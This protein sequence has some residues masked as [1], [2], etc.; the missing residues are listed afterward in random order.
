M[1]LSAMAAGWWLLASCGLLVATGRDLAGQRPLIHEWSALIE[2]D[3]ASPFEVRDSLI[4]AED[5][6]EI[7]GLSYRSPRGGRVTAMLVRPSTPGRHPALLFG[8]WG[9]GNRTEFLAEAK[10]LARLGAVALL[11]DYPWVRPAEWRREEGP[12]DQ[13]EIDRDVRAQ[14]IVDLRRA[15]DLLV[16]RTD[17]DSLRLGYVGHSY[18]AQ[19]G[20]SLAVAERRL[21]AVVL[22][23]GV[24]DNR[25]LLLESDD[26]GLVAYRNRW[27]SEQLARYE[28][29]ISLAASRRYADAGSEPKTVVWYDTGHE[30]N[31]PQALFDRIAWLDRRL[32]LKPLGP[33]IARALA[34]A[35]AR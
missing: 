16:T 10:L 34:R 2:Y 5:A 31:D 12:L 30:L 14:A 13:P 11:I 29:L 3:R 15:L 18:G 6:V 23:A 24:P 35:Q 9:S 27:T 8:H 32:G 21:R 28:P 22:I 25:S 20:A 19:W 7:R 33:E 4:G 1:N 17:V 26:P